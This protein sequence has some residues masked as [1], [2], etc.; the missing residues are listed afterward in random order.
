MRL[1]K[2]SQDSTVLYMQW[3]PYTVHL[4]WSVRLAGGCA[5]CINFPS[6][7]PERTTTNKELILHMQLGLPAEIVSEELPL[8]SKAHCGNA[9]DV[10]TIGFILK[11]FIVKMVD[12]SFVHVFF[13]F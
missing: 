2:D 12:S 4:V 3:P 1:Q 5:S 9:E 6:V 7:S 13:C 10:R 8:K 11:K